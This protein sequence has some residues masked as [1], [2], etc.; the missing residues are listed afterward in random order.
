[1]LP[2]RPVRAVLLASAL[3]PLAVAAASAQRPA[4]AA[5]QAQHQSFQLRQDSSNRMT[6]QVS[7]AGAGPFRFIVDTG[8]ERT[9]VSRQLVEAL[10]LD[11]G[12]PVVVQSVVEQRPS[13]TAIIPHA[14]LGRKQ[15]HNLRA[16]VLDRVDIGADGMI[17]VDVLAGQRVLLDFRNRVMSLSPSATRQ[18]ILADGTIVVRARS[19]AGRLVVTGARANGRRVAAVIDT[20]GE[21]TVGNA[22]LRRQLLGDGRT[23]GRITL[24]SVTGGSVEADFLV[25]DT[26]RLGDVTLGEVAV[27][28]TDSVVFDRL[29]LADRPALLV[30]MNAMSAFDRVSIDFA[31]RKLHLQL[32]ASSLAGERLAAR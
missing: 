2:A 12:P 28:F 6:V 16:P 7:I 22:A 3:L 21:M 17:G 10:G 27:A 18:E 26:L 29:G 30:G 15:L 13:A 14:R 11:S 23:P 8:A 9:I 19:R 31:T 1:M 24:R 5:P 20:G 25:L 4:S 32:K